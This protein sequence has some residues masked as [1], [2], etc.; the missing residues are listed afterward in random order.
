MRIDAK[1]SNHHSTTPV[2]PALLIVIFA[3]SCE[4][5]DNIP[6]P[7]TDEEKCVQ[8]I[9]QHSLPPPPPAQE[10]LRPV[11]PVVESYIGLTDALIN[12]SREFHTPREIVIARNRLHSMTKDLKGQIKDDLNH[13]EKIAILNEYIFEKEAFRYERSLDNLGYALLPSVLQ[14]GKGNCIGLT[15]LYM[16][17]G[18]QLSLPLFGCS[19]K[20]HLFPRLHT[21]GR[22]INIETSDN[23]REHTDT[24]YRE[25][26]KLHPPRVGSTYLRTLGQGEVIGYMK[27]NIGTAFLKQKQFT[28]AASYLT[29]ADS[30]VPNHPEI[31][32]NLG[33]ILLEMGKT[34][35]SIETLSRSVRLDPGR[36]WYWANL[37]QALMEDRLELP[38]IQAYKK[39]LGIDPT[40]YSKVV[41]NLKALHHRL[42]TKY[43]RQRNLQPAADQ[44]LEYLKLVPDDADIHNNLA[45]IYTH[46][47]E[48]RRAWKHV[49]LAGIYGSPVDAAF[50]VKLSRLMPEP[51][52]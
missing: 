45:V 7:V 11:I 38:A 35:Q 46:I 24:E 8:E 47:G 40:L 32:N 44:W 4:K 5:A 6:T 9:A 30:A 20:Q 18:E 17:L 39:A 51:K 3:S 25:R 33:I 13:S 31:L 48:Y 28:K 21:G 26:D 41:E 10:S 43:F 19:S 50:R 37:A 23:G 22:I 14:S 1:T 29:E 12:L 36:A 42:G 16:C 52:K 15:S 2:L 27:S 34:E 49:R